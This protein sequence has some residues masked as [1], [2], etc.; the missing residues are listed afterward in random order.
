MTTYSGYQPVARIPRALQCYLQVTLRSH[1]T[2]QIV[3]LLQ[4]TA[5][6]FCSYSKLQHVK[7]FTGFVHC[8]EVKVLITGG[9]WICLN[10]LGTDCSS[11]VGIVTW[12]RAGRFKVRFCVGKIASFCSS[13]KIGPAVVSTRTPVEWEP[14]DSICCSKAIGRVRL[15]AF[16]QVVLI[17]RKSGAASPFCVWVHGEWRDKCALILIVKFGKYCSC[18]AVILQ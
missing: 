9:P 12:L 3:L 5:G 18:T 7:L 15:A 6:P 11:S 17:L 16:L 1:I 13:L 8:L 2:S 14:V 4:P 10:F